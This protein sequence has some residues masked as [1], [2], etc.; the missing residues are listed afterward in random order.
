MVIE[1]VC[2]AGGGGVSALPIGRFSDAQPHLEYS[3]RQHGRS[4]TRR[5]LPG[6]VFSEA[7]LEAGSGHPAFHVVSRQRSCRG[8][9]LTLQ[10]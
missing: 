5:V 1:T 3:C 7:S 4:P 2:R 6:D 8:R 10:R 9:A